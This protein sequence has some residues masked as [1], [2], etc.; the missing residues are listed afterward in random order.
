[1]SIWFACLA[2][3]ACGYFLTIQT[4][5]AIDPVVMVKDVI[6]AFFFALLGPLIGLHWLMYTKSDFMSRPVFGEKGR[7]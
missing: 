2:W 5:R 7:K 4:F 1:M 3:Y 6:V